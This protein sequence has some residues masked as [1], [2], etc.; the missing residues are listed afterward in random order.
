MAARNSLQQAM[1]VFH[2]VPPERFDPENFLPS[3][4]SVAFRKDLWLEVG[5]YS[6]KL[7]KTGE[8][9]RFFYDIVKTKTRIARVEEAVVFWEEPKNYTLPTFLK[10]SYE[11]AK[12]DVRT[13]IWWHP[14]QRFTSHN[15][16]VLAIFI[17]YIAGLALLT[18]ILFRGLTPLALLVLL[19][20]YIF[21]SVWKWRDVI[22]NWRVRFWLP[23]IQISS[24]IFVMSGFLVGLSGG[25]IRSDGLFKRYS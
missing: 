21:W 14:S 15:I 2:G 22:T 8:D 9:T 18:A 7:E 4:R 19:I 3:A 20:L 11:Y 6:E 24:D 23:V 17:R 25:T 10:K 16:K 1:N 12:G 5:G 13:G